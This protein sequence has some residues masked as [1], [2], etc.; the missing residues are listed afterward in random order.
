MNIREVVTSLRSH[1]KNVVKLGCKQG[2]SHSRPHS[3]KL[4]IQSTHSDSRLSISWE[5][6]AKYMGFKSR[7]KSPKEEAR[8]PA[9]PS[10]DGLSSPAF[11]RTRPVQRPTVWPE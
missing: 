5:G 3:C 1:R 9:T 8:V 10:S 4:P 2:L 6:Q 11:T 7:E